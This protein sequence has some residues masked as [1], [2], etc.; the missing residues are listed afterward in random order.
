MNLR[1][2]L[3]AVS[4]AFVILEG[5]EAWAQAKGD[6]ERAQAK[7]AC[8]AEYDATQSLRDQG[9]LIDARQQAVACSAPTCSVFVTRDC[10]RWLAEIDADL[11]T[12]VLRA[13]NAAGAETAAVR[14]TVD[15]QVIAEKLDGKAA[16]I[17]PGEHIVRFE[18]VGANPV[19]QTVL[20]T[21]GVKNR[22]ILVRFGKTALPI[23]AGRG[24]VTEP[25]GDRVPVW[26]WATGAGGV[27]LLLV[28]G[29]FGV[30]GLVRQGQLVDKCGGDPSHCPASTRDVTVP[31][32]NQRNLDRNVFIGLGAAGVAA[33]V[34]AAVG[35]ARARAKAPDPRTSSFV[36]PLAFRSGGGV[37]A[38]GSF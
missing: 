19:E 30:D 33:V 8:A 15:G 37:A 13:E 38:S 31:I 34:A 7:Q 21:Q 29:G 11:P 3:A 24:P 16:P 32:Y 17:D 26:A 10:A 14:V 6:D 1:Y 23:E 20:I 36:V 9:K 4:I 12:V 28:G 5:A 35:V 2:A 27:T 22:T 25:R 18:I